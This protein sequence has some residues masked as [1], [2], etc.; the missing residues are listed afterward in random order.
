MISSILDAIAKRQQKVG[1]TAVT[2]ETPMPSGFFAY[3][4]SDASV[5]GNPGQMGVGYIFKS[6]VSRIPVAYAGGQIGHGTNNEAEYQSF[7][8]ALRHALRLGI[9]TL[10]MHVD[11]QLLQRQI[12]GRYKVKQSRLKRLHAEALTLTNLFDEFELHYVPREENAEADELSRRIVYVEPNLPPLNP[13]GSKR[14]RILYPFQAAAIRSW[15]LK[16]LASTGVMQRIF[17]VSE[18]LVEQIVEGRTY[19]DATFNLPLLLPPLTEVPSF[20]NVKRV[21]GLNGSPSII[22]EIA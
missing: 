22:A 20:V 14:K 11:S 7:I 5:K 19:R 1:A 15:G 12:K 4:W 17:G 10:I 2:A 6:S 18:N 21:G 8:L 3:G 9:W 13:P 16:K